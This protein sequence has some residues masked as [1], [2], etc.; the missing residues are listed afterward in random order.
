MEKPQPISGFQ[1]SLGRINS[2]DNAVNQFQLNY[3]IKKASY[4]LKYNITSNYKYF[5]Y[6]QNKILNP[7][8]TN[9]TRTDYKVHRLK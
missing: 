3:R 9:G 7:K 4:S 1:V 6:K 2:G 8:T 5:K